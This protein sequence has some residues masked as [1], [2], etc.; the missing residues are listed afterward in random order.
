MSFLKFHSD[1]VACAA[2]LRDL[3]DDMENGRILIAGTVVI[4]RGESVVQ[5]YSYT[6]DMLGEMALSGAHVRAA[7]LKED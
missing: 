3:A 4:R 6:E 5:G 2:Y 1:R 7:T